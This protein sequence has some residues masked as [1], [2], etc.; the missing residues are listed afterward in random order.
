M[1]NNSQKTNKSPI[2]ELKG[3]MAPYIDDP[4][5]NFNA[6][7]VNRLEG[8]NSASDISDKQLGE[9]ITQKVG[10]SPTYE[11][12]VNFL[13]KTVN[14]ISV[15]D[16]IHIYDVKDGIYVPAENYEVG[17][18]LIGV[19]GIIAFRWKSVFEH[20][21]IQLLKRKVTKYKNSDMNKKVF[22]FKYNALDLASLELVQFD[23][24]YL[25]TQKS[26]VDPKAG[27]TPVFDAF[28][29]STFNGDEDKIRF[30]WFW[31]AVHLQIDR[32]FNILVFMYSS[33]AS[34]KSTLLNVLKEILGVTNVTGTSIKDFNGSFG[35]ESMISKYAWILEESGSTITDFSNLKSLAEG[36]TLS[37]NRKNKPIIEV[38]FKLKITLAFNQM[39]IPEM[40]VGFSRR[41]V[42]LVFPNTYIGGKADL[43]LSEKLR[44]EQDSI[45]YE[46]ITRLRK[47]K[48]VY[49]YDLSKVVAGKVKDETQNYLE[50]ARSPVYLFLKEKYTK[51]IGDRTSRS[52]ILNS[53]N[54]FLNE[55]N[56]D[57]KG[58][59][60]PKRFWGEFT[61]QYQE[62][63]GSAPS[64]SKSGI[65]YVDDITLK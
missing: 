65:E 16:E 63:Y 24:K 53:F 30:V 27:D 25:A 62:I 50:G 42:L 58:F 12:V 31:L 2:A 20:E 18:I 10:E 64:F 9:Y 35:L 60:K 11:S 47:L 3:A 21:V 6:Y 39:P 46:L 33:G 1:T 36:N 26:Q 48:T 40:T 34:G 38:A 55:T 29:S 5:G 23:P 43:N 17:R 49:D 59:N 14:L 51:K 32:A 45:A 54:D 37:V 44:K 22:M 13:Q 56:T 19:L 4:K 8:I 52:D 41:L 15:D 57:S 7:I 28:L 61:K